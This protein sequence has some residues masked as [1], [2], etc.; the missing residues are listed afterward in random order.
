MSIT[1]RCAYLDYNASAPV[2]PECVDAMLAVLYGEFGNP[3]SKHR[4]GERAKHRINVAREQVASLLGAMPAE[5]VFTSS[6]TESNHQAILSALALNPTRRHVVTSSVEHPS[7]LQLLRSLEQTQNVRVTYLPVDTHGRLNP[8]LVSG[9]LTSETAL[10][11][12]LWANNETGALFPIGQAAHAAKAKG[13]LF[14]TDAVQAVGKVA[15]NVGDVPADLISF[16][17]HKL[18]A[19]PGIGGLFVRKGLKLPSLLKGHQERGRRGGTENVPGI[20]ALGVACRL[21]ADRL[22]DDVER[23]RTLRDR[24]E[25]GIL[26]RIPVAKVN[27]GRADRVANT[28]NVRFG[29]VSGEMIVDRLDRLGIFVSQGAACSAGGTEPSHVLTAMGLD[30]NCA[31]ASLRFSLGRYTTDAEIDRI[32]DVLPTIV[33]SIAAVAA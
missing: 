32:L 26:E 30:R 5:I 12:L 14:H 31:L 2:A 3:S 29:E 24:L 10:V 7:T 23:V 22:D 25:R 19:P 28:S 6:G 16:S 21:A 20:A 1:G 13:A 18:H 8:Q 17:G 33:N 27:A 9:A 11:T 4:A 15:V